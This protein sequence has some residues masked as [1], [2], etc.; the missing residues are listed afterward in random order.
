MRWLFSLAVLMV[1]GD[2][3]R[4]A[5][6]LVLQHENAVLRRHAG[7]VR[8]HPADGA[9]FAVLTRFWE[10]AGAGSAAGILG[11]NLLLPVGLLFVT[12]PLTGRM[13]LGLLARGLAT[14]T[15]AVIVWRASAAS[16]A[17]GPS[18][19]T[20][21]AAPAALTAGYLAGSGISLD[22]AATQAGPWGHEPAAGRRP[23]ADQ[24]LDHIGRPDGPG[25]AGAGPP[26]GDA[27]R[28]RHRR[29]RRRALVRRMVRPRQPDRGLD[30]GQRYSRLGR[31]DRLVPQPH[32]MVRAADSGTLPGF[33]GGHPARADP[34]LARA[35]PDR[36]GVPPAARRTCA[37]R[38]AGRPGA[39]RRPGRRPRRRD[40]WH[41]CP[42]RRKR[43]CP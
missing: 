42:T 12:H 25:R 36:P 1:R 29:D 11:S 21:L 24:R 26:V 15:L 28:Y 20:W 40:R 7:R 4:D 34:A 33:R 35:G 23:P 10:L 19:R 9:W 22:T 2:G 18:P 30:P 6:L 43:P 5:E 41:R 8:Y 37:A 3:E 16:P 27:G 17:R 14:G 38:D 13:A 31:L 39:D 32:G